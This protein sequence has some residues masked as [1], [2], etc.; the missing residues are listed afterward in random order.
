MIVKDINIKNRSYYFVNDIIN[1]KDFGPDIIKIDE[2]S[3]KHILIYQI[4]YVTDKKE[5]K[6][7]CVNPLLLIFGNQN[8]YF[9]EINENKYLALVP[10]NES[11]EK[12]KKIWRSME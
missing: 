4:G 12:I 3:N 1:I 8:G 5:L 2:K 10:T 6:F 9:Q 7:Y 11:K